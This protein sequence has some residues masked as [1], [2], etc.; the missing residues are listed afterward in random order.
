MSY[1]TDSQFDRIVT[2]PISLPETE[3]RRQRSIR[4]ATFPIALGQ[5]LELRGLT[6]H[7]AKILT[8]GVVPSLDNTV[9]GLCS[10]GLII[11]SMATSVMGNVFTNGLGAACW[12]ADQPVIITAPGTYRLLA[13]NNSSNVDVSVVVTGSAKLFL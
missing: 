13:F 3:L 8:P 5:R 4:V 6:V 9:L 7:L 10:A 12:T 1:I 2:L 11:G